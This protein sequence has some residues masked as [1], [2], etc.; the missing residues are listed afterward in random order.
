MLANSHV[1]W[2]AEKATRKIVLECSNISPV[3]HAATVD[4]DLAIFSTGSNGLNAR[5]L[6]LD[7]F[8]TVEV[9]TLTPTQERQFIPAP[10]WVDDA[11][12]IYLPEIY[13]G[14]EKTIHR[15]DSVSKKF[16]EPFRLLQDTFNFVYHAHDN[17]LYTVYSKGHVTRIDLSD[18]ELI[19]VPVLKEESDFAGILSAGDQLIV[20]YSAYDVSY[21]KIQRLPGFPKDYRM[22]GNERKR[23]YTFQGG[24]VYWA[25]QL[26]DGSYGSEMGPRPFGY[27]PGVEPE[28]VFAA[29]GTQVFLA[30][31][32]VMNT[33]KFIQTWQLPN[34]NKDFEWHQG[35]LYSL[36]QDTVWIYGNRDYPKFSEV[37][38]WNDLY[39]V[40][41]LKKIPGRP[42]QLLSTDEGLVLSVETSGFLRFYIMDQNLKLL[43]ASEVLGKNSPLSLDSSSPSKVLLSFNHTQDIPGAVDLEWFSP[44]SESWQILES[45]HNTSSRR[46]IGNLEAGTELHF[47][48][49]DQDKEQFLSYAD[50]VVFTRFGKLYWDATAPRK[51]ENRVQVFN[52]STE[53]WETLFTH[54][55]PPDNP[56]EWEI[57]SIG[58]YQPLEA[59]IQY[60]DNDVSDWQTSDI[61]MNLIVK[62]RISTI[63]SLGNVQPFEF[64][65]LKPE[66]GIWM[67][68]GTGHL[69]PSKFSP[70]IFEHEYPGPWFMEYDV[71]EPFWE[72]PRPYGFLTVTTPSFEEAQFFQYQVSIDDSDTGGGVLGNLETYTF[73]DRIDLR[74]VAE[75]GLIFSHWNGVEDDIRFGESLQLTADI[76]IYLKPHFMPLSEWEV[77][78]Y[79]IN[80]SP[81]NLWISSSSKSGL[82]YEIQKSTD[83]KNWS[84]SPVSVEGTGSNI[85]MVLSNE[86]LSPAGF[87]RFR[88]HPKV[89]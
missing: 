52:Q 18:P 80:I 43:Y 69:T 20:N 31:G 64:R 1:I 21:Q 40:E 2:L 75:S 87:Y 39:E 28:P 16:L 61:S 53:Q 86:W 76:N 27:I 19:E 33:E 78:D 22:W 70:Q 66:S 29:D 48:V 46:M 35:K 77:P 23:V 24:Q 65:L 14:A 84:T 73:G 49:A 4:G 36:R 3:V 71:L 82:V 50:K 83:L 47:R 74:A 56:F 72:E 38:K 17:S 13:Y 8:S 25:D 63:V 6:T 9:S 30:S 58:N 37:R 12:V 42:V 59:R 85:D 67:K 34:I 7:D 54:Q 55:N 44:D 26:E 45:F 51:F 88:V 89:P 81:Q 11:N 60:R 32:V 15:W 57:N 41:L 79:K 10:G 5:L 68:V 62:T